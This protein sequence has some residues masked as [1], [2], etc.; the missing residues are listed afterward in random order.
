MKKILFILGL[1]LFYTLYSQNNLIKEIFTEFIGTE[2]DNGL[3]HF[4]TDKNVTL[5]PNN[6][7]AH[8]YYKTEIKS[9]QIDSIKTEVDKICI[10]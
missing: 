1:F 3:I 4:P 6:Y 2:D 10:T 7:N 9:E 5:Y 8:G